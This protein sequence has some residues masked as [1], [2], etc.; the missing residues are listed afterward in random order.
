MTTAAPA[1]RLTSNKVKSV[2]DV[3]FENLDEYLGNGNIDPIHP[4]IMYH[5]SVIERRRLNVSDV[6]RQAGMSREMLY[7]ILRGEASITASSAI[8]LAEVA[9][10]Q[11]DF[12]LRA[13]V[14]FDLWHER[15]RRREARLSL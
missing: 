10:N 9:G 6:A 2:M 3:S 5:V 12:W 1:R 8:G 13:Q 15:N 14:I 7:R 11:P 4:G